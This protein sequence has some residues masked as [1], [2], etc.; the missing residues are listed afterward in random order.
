MHKMDRTSHQDDVS[1]NATRLFAFDNAIFPTN[2]LYS[3]PLPTFLENIEQLGRISRNAVRVI[4]RLKNLP[5]SIRHSETKVFNL[6]E[7]RWYIEMV[8]L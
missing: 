1:K 8:T 7:G 4:E 5:G 2:I 6:S 3:L